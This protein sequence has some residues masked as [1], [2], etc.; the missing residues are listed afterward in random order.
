MTGVERHSLRNAPLASPSPVRPVVFY[1]SAPPCC[2][3][4][5]MVQQS[6]SIDT[7]FLLNRT[8]L[9]ASGSWWLRLCATGTAG[10]ATSILLQLL[11][12]WAF[13]ACGTS[14]HQ[15][16]DG[17]PKTV[18]MHTWDETGRSS[19]EPESNWHACMFLEPRPQWTG[20]RRFIDK[21]QTKATEKHNMK[22]QKQQIHSNTNKQNKQEQTKIK[23]KSKNRTTPKNINKNN[24][25][26]EQ[27]KN[28]QKKPKPKKTKA[29]NTTPKPS[30]RKENKNKPPPKR[31]PKWEEKTGIFNT[32]ATLP[33]TKPLKPQKTN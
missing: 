9:L 18:H 7:C 21:N 23:N 27:N 4:V 31:P 33:A 12:P 13:K 19:P 16:S 28:K 5:G 3:L 26:K 32:S 25:K 24:T 11:L 20:G 15:V 8:R 17:S 6:W 22:T 30:K 2:P 10:D 1:R 29:R 14:I